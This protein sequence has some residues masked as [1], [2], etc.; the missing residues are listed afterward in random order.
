M[1]AQVRSP[2][3]HH[4]DVTQ[5]LGDVLLAAGAQVR[6]A[7]LVGLHGR[8][9]DLFVGSFAGHTPVWRWPLPNRVSAALGASGERAL[10]DPA[11]PPKGPPGLASGAR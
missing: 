1:A 7:R 4:H 8:D 10:G 6:L 2:T 11:E 5:A 3:W 9:L